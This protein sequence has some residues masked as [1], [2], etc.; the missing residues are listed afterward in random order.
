[1]TDV[2]NMSIGQNAA[3]ARKGGKKAYAAN[4][5]AKAESSTSCAFCWF[6]MGIYPTLDGMIDRDSDTFKLHLEK[7][8]GLCAEIQQ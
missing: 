2:T 1:M 5:Q 3:D 6:V 4:I 8:H 7:V